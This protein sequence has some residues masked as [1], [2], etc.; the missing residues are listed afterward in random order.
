MGE[1][2]DG[3]PLF[4]GNDLLDQLH[5][6]MEVLGGLTNDLKEHYILNRK[7]RNV[8]L[9]TVENPITLKTRYKK[10]FS[11][12]ELEFLELLLQ[13][14]PDNRPTAREAINHQYFDD[15]REKESII[16]TRSIEEIKSSSIEGKLATLE[17]ETSRK[18]NTESSQKIRI[19]RVD[20][21]IIKSE[22]SDFQKAASQNVKPSLSNFEDSFANLRSMKKVNIPK[23]YYNQGGG[24]NMQSIVGPS[25]PLYYI[26]SF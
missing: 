3:K 1:L 4:P 11:G 13:L 21:L 6:T 7:L 19:K 5:R 15:I 16:K 20:K 8:K 17:T 25:N 10:L 22:K 14:S 12:V 18:G 24:G 26:S 23:T 2:V 9:K